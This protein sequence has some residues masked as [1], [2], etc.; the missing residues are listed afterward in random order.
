M[1]ELIWLIMRGCV[2]YVSMLT[3]PI[4]LVDSGHYG[5]AIIVILLCI[6]WLLN[7]NL[8]GRN[9]NDR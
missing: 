3:I 5:S 4:I 1:K 6:N 9:Y 7:V 8:S 2:V